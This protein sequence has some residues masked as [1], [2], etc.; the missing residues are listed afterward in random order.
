MYYKYIEPNF[1]ERF[2]KIVRNWNK[3]VDFSF[4]Q[5]KEEN[6]RLSIQQVCD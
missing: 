1:V 5:G 6:Q 4:R 2:V 3:A